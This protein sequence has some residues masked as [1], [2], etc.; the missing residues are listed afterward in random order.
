MHMLHRGTSGCL[1]YQW[2]KVIVIKCP[3]I[4]E[5]SSKMQV[6]I[7]QYYPSKIISVHAEEE[8]EDNN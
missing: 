3:N 4:I 5:F 6:L 2:C 8:R 7:M 1:I